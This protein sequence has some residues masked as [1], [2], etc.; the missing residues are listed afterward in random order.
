M[1]IPKP[2]RH[3]QHPSSSS[4]SLPVRV[5]NEDSAEVMML[6]SSPSCNSIQATSNAVQVRTEN[7]QENQDEDDDDDE[8]KLH[9]K[10]PPPPVPPPSSSSSS[11][12]CYQYYYI[13]SPPLSQLPQQQQLPLLPSSSSSP[14]ST[15][16]ITPP[17][18]NT[19]NH[20]TV[21][22]KSSPSPL[23]LNDTSNDNDND[24]DDVCEN[25]T[26]AFTNSA[27]TM[28]ST[29]NTPSSEYV[30]N[31]AFYSFVGF[32]IVQGF[33][34]YYIA[35]SSA[36]MADCE[37]MSIDALTYLF[38]LLAERQKN[39]QYAVLNN[40]DD[41][42]QSQYRH[43]HRILLMKCYYEFIP[44][45]LSVVTLMMVTMYT[46]Q[47]SIVTMVQAHSI[48]FPNTN[49][50]ITTTNHD[51]KEAEDVS[52]PIMLLFSLIN[53]VLDMVNVTCFARSG[54][55]T[56]TTTSTT[57]TTTTN[58]YSDSNGT[59]CTITT[60]P[61]SGTV[62]PYPTIHHETTPL[63]RNP[64]FGKYDDEEQA[65]D[66]TKDASDVNL[67]MC[68]AWTHV[69]AD[70]MRSLAVVLAAGIAMCIPTP[71][72]IEEQ[73]YAVMA[74][75]MAA[76]V[77]SIIILLSIVPL[78]QGIYRTG[79]QIIQLHREENDHYLYPKVDG[80]RTMS[81]RTTSYQTI[82]V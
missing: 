31:V 69:C 27:T 33:V 77:V 9:L 78:L 66:T 18:S 8:P 55:V 39:R 62:Q 54:F 80:G 32:M 52:I 41:D 53:L 56:T 5:N 14:T 45:L 42:P 46:I 13:S 6:L 20:S 60:P 30:L 28:T 34:A 26:P 74:D 57:T 35:H 68:S 59:Q 65:A 79:Q 10:V 58:H 44:P 73:Y 29:A 17:N 47:T 15:M 43:H 2:H 21:M 19:T 3:H 49:D 25:T 50:V 64:S 51:I 76:L 4:S 72:H 36:M 12:S 61:H 48:Q 37:A 67:N 24:D 82:T 70:T 40:N 16:T 1:G 81:G 11:L 22:M 63:V 23:A 38:N 75:S 71:N 7:R